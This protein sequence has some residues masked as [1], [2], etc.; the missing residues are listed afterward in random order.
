MTR[1][2][3]LTILQNATGN[4]TTGPIFETLPHLADALNDALN[5]ATETRITKP[6][7]TR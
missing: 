7:E 3:I 6:K 1:D 5:P 4:P 2:Q